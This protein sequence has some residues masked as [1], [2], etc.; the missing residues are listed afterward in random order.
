MWF[1]DLIWSNIIQCTIHNPQAAQNKRTLLAEL[2]E[3]TTCDYVYD[4]VIGNIKRY[5]IH[6][7]QLR[8]RQSIII[9]ES[10]TF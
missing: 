4:V 2:V 10:Q 3:N 5:Y 7:E 8:I 6:M 9:Y 1:P